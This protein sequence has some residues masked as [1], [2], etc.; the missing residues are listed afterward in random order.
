MTDAV[1]ATFFTSLFGTV[2]AVVVTWLRTR[3]IQSSNGTNL[4]V[5][6]RNHARLEAK[7]DHVW[8]GVDQVRGSVDRHTDQI[9]NM[10]AE[11]ASHLVAENERYEQV[12]A[13]AERIAAHMERTNG[14][15]EAIEADIHH[16]E[17]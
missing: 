9:A 6:H 3:K 4:D 14:E 5:L 13:A 8:S 2:T 11:F 12:A 10:R 16:E 7:I 1:W 17:G 15:L